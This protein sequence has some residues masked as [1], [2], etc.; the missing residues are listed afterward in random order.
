MFQYF[1]NVLY[2][3]I[4]DKFSVKFGIFYGKLVFDVEFYSSFYER[5]Y[6]DINYVVI[7]VIILEGVNL[8]FVCF[9]KI[10]QLG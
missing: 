6:L 3:I 1:R 9:K 4:L 8:F 2:L 5:C 10:C 7:V